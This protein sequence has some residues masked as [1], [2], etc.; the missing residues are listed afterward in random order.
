MG[1]THVGRLGHGFRKNQNGCVTI[2]SFFFVSL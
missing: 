2:E 1:L